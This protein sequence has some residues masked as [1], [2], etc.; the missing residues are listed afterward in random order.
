MNKVV[1]VTVRWRWALS[2]ASS[3][4]YTSLFSRQCFQMVGTQ[5]EVCLIKKHM[6]M[7]LP[8][9]AKSRKHQI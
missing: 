6:I 1:S 4:A 9:S 5:E 3:M 8:K 7:E 2:Y